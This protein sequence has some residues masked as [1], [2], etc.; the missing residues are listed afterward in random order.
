MNCERQGAYWWMAIKGEERRVDGQ[1]VT[2]MWILILTNNSIIDTL[3]FLSFI[4]ITSFSKCVKIKANF[5][6]IILDMPLQVNKEEKKKKR[7]SNQTCKL[8]QN[9]KKIYQEQKPRDMQ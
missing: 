7:K 6:Y 8:W 1:I 3:G 5:E 9:E 2:I 4:A